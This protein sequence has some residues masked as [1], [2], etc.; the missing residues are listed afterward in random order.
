MS[1]GGGVLAGCVIFV[2]PEVA[3]DGDMHSMS[4]ALGCEDE[5]LQQLKLKLREHGARVVD[6]VAASCT[7]VL[8]DRARDDPY[9]DRLIGTSAECCVKIV[10][11]VW[12]EDCIRHLP[13]LHRRNES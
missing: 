10:P 9:I 7:H 2:D 12:V 3:D 4:Q 11:P 13:V 5:S 6:E 8:S 1:A